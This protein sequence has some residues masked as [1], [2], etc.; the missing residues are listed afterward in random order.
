MCDLHA[1]VIKSQSRSP[2]QWASLLD[3]PAFEATVHAL[4]RVLHD[5][6]LLPHAYYRFA[7]DPVSGNGA[8]FAADGSRSAVD[9]RVD[10]AVTHAVYFME[11]PTPHCS[12]LLLR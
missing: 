2:R 12:L 4:P 9:P 6:K 8:W 5:K 11:F 1:E 10:A 3:S 7:Y